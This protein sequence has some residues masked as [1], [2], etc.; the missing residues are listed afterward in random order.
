[1]ILEST[2]RL[3]EA[4]AFSLK[5]SVTV[6]FRPKRAVTDLPDGLVYAIIP[7]VVAVKKSEYV[8]GDEGGRNV[9]VD[10]GCCVD[11]AVISRPVKRQPPFYKRVRGF[12]VCADITRRRFTAVL[13]SDTELD[14][15]RASIVFEAGW[16]WG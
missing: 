9:D 1:L 10:H 16:D 2:N 7:H 5:T 13:V 4:F 8:S 3:L 11:F 15:S 14:E 6:N 12:E